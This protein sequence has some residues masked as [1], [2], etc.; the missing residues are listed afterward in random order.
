[1]SS[2]WGGRVSDKY[3]TMNCGFLEKLQQGDLVLADRGFDIADNVGLHAG[4]VRF[5]IPAFTRGKKQL[6][7][8]DVETTRRL[9]NVRIHVERVIGCLQQK[10]T[11]LAGT[12]PIDYAQTRGSSTTT[13]DKVALVCAALVNLSDSVVP[14][15]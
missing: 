3:L 6:S 4:E 15:D 12:I 11:I 2:G 1:M 8:A 13:I 5:E 9:A 7:P 10:Y 14:F